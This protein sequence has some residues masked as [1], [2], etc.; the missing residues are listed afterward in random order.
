V[1]DLRIIGYYLGKAILGLGLVQLVPLALA[2]WLRS[3]D[4]VSALAS[5]VAIAVAI[6]LVSDWRL[7][8]RRDLDWAHGLVIV[9]LAWLVGTAVLATPMYLSGHFGTYLDAYLEMMSA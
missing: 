7:H 1:D 4:D 5:G 6:G 3:W 9:A 2:V 8:T